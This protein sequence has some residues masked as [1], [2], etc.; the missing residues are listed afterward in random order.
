MQYIIS[1]SFEYV[2]IL[3]QI[4]LPNK[5]FGKEILERCNI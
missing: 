2:S 5:M 1:L 4:Y 3:V